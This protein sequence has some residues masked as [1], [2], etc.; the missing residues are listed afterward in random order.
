MLMTV[1]AIVLAIL[2]IQVIFIVFSKI[3]E[4]IAAIGAP[5]FVGLIPDE[6]SKEEWEAQYNNPTD[7]STK[8]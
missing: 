3:I 1:I 4:T 5:I 8:K 7:E 6:M 2:I